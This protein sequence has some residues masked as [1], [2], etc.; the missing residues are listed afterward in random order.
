MGR[1]TKPKSQITYLG[2]RPA[3]LRDAAGKTTG[4]RF[5]VGGYAVSRQEDRRNVDAIIP[6]KEAP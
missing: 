6:E 1:H 2:G 3:E 4:M 5:S